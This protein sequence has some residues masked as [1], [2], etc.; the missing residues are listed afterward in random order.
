MIWWFYIEYLV[1]FS[2]W[3]SP[4]T[5]VKFVYTWI[6]TPT[7]CIEFCNITVFWRKGKQKPRIFYMYQLTIEVPSSIPSLLLNKVWTLMRSYH[8]HSLRISLVWMIL[9]GRLRYTTWLKEP[10]GIWNSLQQ[11]VLVHRVWGYFIDLIKLG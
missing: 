3:A 7:S 2:C 6:S 1:Y 4:K 10:F 9:G 8:H 5:Y 11:T